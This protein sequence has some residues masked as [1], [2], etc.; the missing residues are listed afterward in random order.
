MFIPSQKQSEA[1][2]RLH[3]KANKNPMLGDLESLPVQKLE[4]MA[5][6]RSLDSWMKQE[7][8]RAWFLNSESNRELL[9]S[10]VETGLREVLRI[11]EMPCDGEKGSPKPSDKLNAAKLFLEYAG[12]APKKQATVEYKDKEI[13]EM[14]AETLDKE[15]LKL[16]KGLQG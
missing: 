11:L 2:A 3:N 12:Y 9:E 10:G 8:F 7:G 16:H 14:D 4:R 15:I 13:A 1:K 5:G 6:V